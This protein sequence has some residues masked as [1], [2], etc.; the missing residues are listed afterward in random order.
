MTE[1]IPK[2]QT[3]QDKIPETVEIKK[4][5][6]G[7]ALKYNDDIEIFPETRL[8]EYDN[9]EV[10]AYRAV[11]KSGRGEMLYAMVCETHLVPRF[12]SISAY[13]SIGDH[14]VSPLLSSGVMHWAPAGQERFVFIY[15]DILGRKILNGPQ[16]AAGW[17]QDDVMSLVI[18]PLVSALQ[19]MREKNFV[20]GSIRPSNM[21]FGGPAGKPER[22]ILG[23]C[24]SVPASSTQSALYEPIERAMAEPIGRGEGSNLDDIYAFGVTVAVLLRG[25]DPLEGLNEEEILQAKLELGSYN[26]VTGK[27]R[28]KGSILELLRGVLQDDPAQR[29]SI[30]EIHTWMDG[31]RL[32]PKQSVKEKK[33]PRPILFNGQKYFL[34][35]ML[36]MDLDKNPPDTV[37]MVESGDLK[38]WLT[39]SLEDDEA[40]ERVE[41]ALK[42]ARDKGSG[43]GYDERLV[44]LLSAALDPRAP[45]RYRGLRVL[46]EG[47]GRA[48]VS[49][50]VLKKDI[51]GFA[52]L[53]IQ[54]IAMSWLTALESPGKDTG[55]LISRFDA[56]RNYIR[57]TKIGYGLERCIYILCPEVHCLSDRLL[58]YF[59]RSPEEMMRAF[60]DICQKNKAPGLLLDRHS[61]AFISV[62]D[63][64]VIDSFLFDLAAPQEH[65]RILGNL[66]CFATIQKRDNMRPYPGIAQSFANMLPV[67]CE[68]YHDR[69][70]REKLK[71]NIA[72]HVTEGDLVKMASL[73]SS[74]DLI[75]R[76]LMSFREAQ[77]EYQLL[78]HEYRVLEI[79]L[80]HK[81]SFGKS[82]G[83]EVAAVFSAIVAAVI[84]FVIATMTFSKQTP[85]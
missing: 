4:P 79:G 47:I 38:Q 19:E 11:A 49:A 61:A 77:Y 66:K 34:S 16:Q 18:R 70:L 85:F 23:D 44:A 1:E 6:K 13:A 71:K 35:S 63:P 60:E 55:T 56:C 62:R 64:K 83:R 45:L 58:G 51:Q 24:L 50:T 41:A 68:S 28:F 17:R 20:H 54:N 12:W 31:R 9:G 29:W 33:A 73:L 5:G 67:L 36:A 81:S 42:T 76:D 25:N 40:L 78:T 2:I 10:K 65:K 37:R 57:H 22:V 46:G 72:R 59:V 80:E 30:G 82:S 3:R 32:S 26:A 15:R 14:S 48:L 39:R 21:F 43:P 8:P 52:E 74:P 53:F 7:T 27:E 69:E 75:T 84:I